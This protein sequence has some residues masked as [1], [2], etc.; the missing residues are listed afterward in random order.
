MNPAENI[1][2][3]RYEIKFAVDKRDYQKAKHAI[4]R[5]PLGFRVHHPDRWVNNVYFDTHNLQ[6]FKENLAGISCRNK[7]RFRWYGNTIFPQVGNLELKVRRNQY[8]WKHTFKCHN[9]NFPDDFA[10]S[11]FVDLLVGGMDEAA[12]LLLKQYPNPVIQNQYEREYF[13]SMDGDIRATIDRHQKARPLLGRHHA[14][15]GNDEFRD[16]EMVIIEF[17]TSR[18]NYSN[19]SFA[20]NHFPCRVSKNS[21][22]VE[23]ILRSYSEIM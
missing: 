22:Y 23:S 19:L 4:L 6:C 21:K 13:I 17:K 15:V 11:G 5:H 8:G 7:L 9:A 14:L 2:L 18:L 12:W 10:W 20:L 1:D 16:I 3:Q